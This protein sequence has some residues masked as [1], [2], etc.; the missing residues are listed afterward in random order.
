[1]RLV[2]LLSADGCWSVMRG[3]SG[4]GE[5]LLLEKV[6]VPIVLLPLC[7]HIGHNW[8]AMIVAESEQFEQES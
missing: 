6:V 7:V 2:H 1:M 5:L 8:R 4:R 3:F